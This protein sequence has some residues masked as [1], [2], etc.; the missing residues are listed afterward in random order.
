MRGHHYLCRQG[1]G[2]EGK[3]R[4]ELDRPDSRGSKG[5]TCKSSI[6]SS[7]IESVKRQGDRACARNG[8]GSDT[9][10]RPGLV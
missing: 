10:G 3:G 5:A 4:A 9:A 2:E 6:T 7:G 1:R 8:S